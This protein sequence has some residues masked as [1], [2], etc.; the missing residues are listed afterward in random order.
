M[1][2]V[3]DKL[4]IRLDLLESQKSAVDEVQTSLN[5]FEHQVNHLK[6]Q[7]EMLT[8]RLDNLASKPASAPS[9]RV[10]GESD[11][12]INI[13]LELQ[14][15]PG[16]T[17]GLEQLL[18]VVI[19]HGASDLHLKAGA[20]P[21]VRLNGDLIPIGEKPLTEEECRYL[22]FSSIPFSKRK[23]FQFI[24]E[25]DHA[26]VSSGVRFRLNA[27]LERGRVS[28]AFRAVTTAIPGF[29]ALGLPP[30]M[31]S[32]AM[33]HHGLVLVTGPA[34]SGKSTTLAAMVDFIN[35]NRKCHVVTIEDPIEFYHHD[36]NSFITQR[37]VGTDTTGFAEALRQALRQ[38]P[39][40]I[41]VGEMRDTETI[42]TA[43]TAAETGHLVL[44]TLHT[45][46]AVQAIDRIVDNFSG[47]QQRQIRQLLSSSLKGVI[48]QKLLTRADGRGRIPALEIL[49]CTS[50]IASH[51]LDGQTKE[52]YQYLQ[53]GAHEGMQTFTAH[54]TRLVEQ[55]LVTK[56]E[57]LFHADQANEFKLSLRGPAGSGYAT[58]PSPGG[59]GGPEG[60]GNYVNWL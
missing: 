46:N 56:E 15:P 43:V 58:G 23:R 19:Q 25:V 41:M 28:A 10:S 34:G 6:A 53:Q 39:N 47:D 44:S 18:R 49:V 51:I 9:P 40:V 11:A 57:A 21:T 8:V 59:P 16:M 29:Q 7:V 36:E 50:T 14:K 30:V 60:G 4:N 54:L 5:V 27:F 20:P 31:Q 17:F 38:D 55:G 22:V 3:V 37:E 35:K 26:H 24:K 48:S 32:L 52:I 1:R 45:P 42:M 2:E 33:I 12:E 13:E